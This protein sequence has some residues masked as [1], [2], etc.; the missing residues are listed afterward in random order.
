M[1]T[2]FFASLA[3]LLLTACTTAQTAAKG[4]KLVVMGDSRQ[5]RERKDGEPKSSLEKERPGL[6]LLLIDGVD[7]ALIYDML[8]KG[9]LPHLA[10]LLGG[11]LEHAHLDET[12]LSTLPSSTMVAWSTALTGVT[13]AEHGIAGNEFFIRETLQFAAPVPVT[14]NSVKPVLDNF[15]DD[16]VD[17][18]R[19][20]PSVYERMRE[21]DP[22]ILVWVAMHMFH[23]GADRLLLTNRGMIAKAFE[24]FV[25]ETV[26]K[27][28]AREEQ[29]DLFAKLDK[30]V[31]DVVIEQLDDDPLPD[32]LT[33]YLSGTDSFAH[34]ADD[35]PDKARR[36]Y[37]K[38]V[39]E[40]QYQR[41]ADKLRERGAL[42]DRYV[43]L[44]SDH[45]HTEVLRDDHHALST[46]GDDEPPMV[47]KK[48][49]FRVRPFELEV[50]EKEPFDAVLAYQGAMA[51]VYLA[52]RSGCA[53]EKA[54]C[55]WGKPP[56]Y[57]EDVLAAAEAYYH[58]DETGSAVPEMKGAIDMVLARKPVPRAEDDLPFEV[59]V[60]NGKLVPVPEWLAAHP[61][62]NYV[63][64]DRRLRDLAVGAHGERAG[65]IILIAHNGDQ[66]SPDKRYYFA[67]LYRSWHGSPSKQDSEIPLIVAHPRRTTAQLAAFTK[68]VIG[69]SPRQQ[70]ITD[71]LLALRAA[72]LSK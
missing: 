5:L 32:V 60:G 61:H 33:V 47:L 67:S 19:L 12:V 25:E 48:A 16:Y 49:G 34:V 1:K 51:Y 44:T 65:D 62:P 45:G 26:E 3:V 21:T 23:P 57:E 6:L 52:D 59:Y 27:L 11:G 64:L 46:K 50:S 58:N 39:L 30:A 22:N 38:E 43:V 18:L 17:K 69:E 7:R 10:S 66:D 55:D 40:P 72:E 2:A 14:I 53:T 29:R 68:K 13:P 8:K 24:R 4:V 35:G 63:A 28:L 20:A 9:E 15:A 71:L 56:R 54:V 36:D 41:L 70:K 37:L 42:E 31:M